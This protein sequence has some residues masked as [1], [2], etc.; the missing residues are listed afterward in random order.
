MI[1]IFLGFSPKNS[2][3]QSGIRQQIPVSKIIPFAARRD[4]VSLPDRYEPFSFALAVCLEPL[5]KV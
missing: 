2:P 3:H 4:D 1:R 5:G